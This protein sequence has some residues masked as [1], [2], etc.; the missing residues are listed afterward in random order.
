M[1]FTIKIIERTIV[2]VLSSRTGLTTRSELFFPIV[3]TALTWF[4]KKSNNK[5][6]GDETREYNT[7]VSGHW[8]KFFTIL[9]EYKRVSQIPALS[10]SIYLDLIELDDYFWKNT[11]ARSWEKKCWYS[12]FIRM[13]K[14]ERSPTFIFNK[15]GALISIRY[16]VGNIRRSNTEQRDIELPAVMEEKPRS[17]AFPYISTIKILPLC[18]Q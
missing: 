5:K 2:H 17:F 13:K 14:V 16:A 8:R 9:P 7:F 4:S 10:N 11:L 12:K 18:G 3:N 15:E 6:T 1:R